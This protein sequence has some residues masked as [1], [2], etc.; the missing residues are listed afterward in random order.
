MYCT[1]KSSMVCTRLATRVR[2]SEYVTTVWAVNNEF[3]WCTC[4]ELSKRDGMIHSFERINHRR[5]AFHLLPLTK[6]IESI[7]FLITIVF[8]HGS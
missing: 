5:P 8:S 3:E 6:R 4:Q 2:S 7:Y 1:Y